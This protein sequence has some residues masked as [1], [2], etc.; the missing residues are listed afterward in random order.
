MKK[1]RGTKIEIPDV[2]CSA[3]KINSSNLFLPTKMIPGV[4]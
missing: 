4:E 3:Y 2:L 1:N